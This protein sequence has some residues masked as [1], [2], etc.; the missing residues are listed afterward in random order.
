MF[1]CQ[2]NWVEKMDKSEAKSSG[3][4][5]KADLAENQKTELNQDEEESEVT[6]STLEDG[7]ISEEEGQ[8]LSD[9]RYQK[10]LTT[11]FTF[12]SLESR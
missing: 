11:R 1:L 7:E 3:G 4:A 6:L 9:V 10:M 5:E 2:G 12:K 8:L